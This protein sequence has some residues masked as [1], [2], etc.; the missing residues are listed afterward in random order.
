METQIYVTPAVKG[1]NLDGMLP[2]NLIQSNRFSDDPLLI[3][4]LSY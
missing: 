4:C 2:T 1:L 3:M